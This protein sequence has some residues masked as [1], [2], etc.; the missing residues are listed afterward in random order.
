MVS[1]GVDDNDDDDYAFV[2]R[3]VELL[4]ICSSICP[5][6]PGV[7]CDHAVHFSADLSLRLDSLMSGAP[8][9]QSCPSTPNHDELRERTTY[10]TASFSVFVIFIYKLDVIRKEYIILKSVNTDRVIT[11]VKG[12]RFFETDTV[13]YVWTYIVEMSLTECDNYTL[14]TQHT[15]RRKNSQIILQIKQ[16][17]QTTTWL[18]CMATMIVVEFWT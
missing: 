2:E 4:S 12:E 8:W 13:L 3:I 14:C 6:G 17:R 16:Q 5:S 1:I 11:K 9:H 7:H 18:S 10:D 15:L